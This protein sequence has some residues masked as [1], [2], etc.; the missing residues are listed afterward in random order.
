MMSSLHHQVESF[1]DS[2]NLTSAEFSDV[3]LR[4][5][6]VDVTQVTEDF[7]L[8]PL[9]D[10]TTDI[11]GNENYIPIEFAGALSAVIFTVSAS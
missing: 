9:L 11:H 2:N 6:I 7:S 5:V 1:L 8:S 3:G 10:N 4:L